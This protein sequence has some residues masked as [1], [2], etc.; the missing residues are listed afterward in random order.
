[1]T[2]ES[3]EQNVQGTGA[4]SDIR[5]DKFSLIRER[6]HLHPNAEIRDIVASLEMDGIHVTADEVRDVLAHTEH[7]PA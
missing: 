4:S 7:T 3:L 1:M 6:L 2:K 5:G